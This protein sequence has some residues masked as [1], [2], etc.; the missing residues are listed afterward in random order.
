MKGEIIVSF[1]G[2]VIFRLC[3]ST[4]Y[5]YDVKIIPGGRTDIAQHST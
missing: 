5:M 4:G 3:D 1:K 2:R